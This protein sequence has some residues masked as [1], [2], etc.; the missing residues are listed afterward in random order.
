MTL[1]ALIIFGVIAC[2]WLAL[3]PR[4]NRAKS[5]HYTEIAFVVLALLLFHWAPAEFAPVIRVFLLMGVSILAVA[6]V[7][8]ILGS[9][10]ANH[11]IMDVLYACMAVVAGAV[12]LSQSAT[13]WSPLALT[14]FVLQLI[15]GARLVSHVWGTNMAV[16]QQPYATMRKYGGARWKYWSFFS[17]Y[18]LQGVLIWFWTL[19]AAFV[20][21]SP[22]GE[23]GVS[24]YLGLAVWVVGFIFQA[25]GD[26][27]LKRF[28]ADPANAGKVMQSGLWSLTRHPN[29][30]GEILMWW[31]WFLF[32]LQHPWGWL[33]IVG[34]IYVTWFM[35]FGS[36]VPGNE[37]HMRKS[38]GA[39]YDEYAA[40]V[41]RLVPRLFR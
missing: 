37:R 7:G 23:L 40:R 33:S 24:S 9:L 30:L 2:L 35:A 36:A 17:V 28:K 12:A 34:P 8:W 22:T 5:W 1:A 11:S 39:A 18:V 20:M 6:V 27:Q 19:P 26:L 10:R 3:L 13:G 14:F 38:R 31:G 4:D 41:P 32:A 29:Y 21:L 15:W 16:E 25:G